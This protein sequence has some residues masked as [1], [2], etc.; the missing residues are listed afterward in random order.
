MK[1]F[2]R[3][4]FVVYMVLLVYVIVFKLGYAI[5]HWNLQLDPQVML[6]K[7][8]SGK[9]VNLIPFAY[10]GSLGVFLIRHTRGELMANTVAFIPMGILL[11]AVFESLRK[12]WKFIIAALL[13]PCFFELVQLITN[14]GICDVHD[15]ILNFAGSAVGFIFFK[16]IRMWAHRQE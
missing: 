16:G 15:L 13:I 11:P 7:I 6:E 5:K 4:L 12:T 2:C 10:D 8:I 9:G 1:E 3:A 14:M